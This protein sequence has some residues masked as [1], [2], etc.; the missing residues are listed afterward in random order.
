MGA[1]GW[2]TDPGEDSPVYAAERTALVATLTGVTLTSEQAEILVQKI[3]IAARGRRTMGGN[4]IE[5]IQAC[6]SMIT[7][8]LD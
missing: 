3:I 5:H 6:L 7:E 4:V 1:P 2:Q 8:A